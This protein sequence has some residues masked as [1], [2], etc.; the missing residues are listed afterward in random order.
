MSGDETPEPAPEVLWEGPH[1]MFASWEARVNA[2]GDVEERGGGDRTWYGSE[3]GRNNCRQ[4]A[5]HLARLLAAAHSRAASLERELAEAQAALKATSA[6]NS[7]AGILSNVMLARDA[8][9]LR[10]GKAEGLLREKAD[11]IEGYCFVSVGPVDDDEIPTPVEAPVAGCEC[12]SCRMAVFLAG[13]NEG[14]GNG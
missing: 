6:G 9:L 7:L 12:L 3:G 8:A 2:E 14:G 13:D 5:A 4:A 1:W 10:L 11:D